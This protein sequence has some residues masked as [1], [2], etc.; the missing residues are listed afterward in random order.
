MGKLSTKQLQA[1]LLIIAALL[2]WI[3]FRIPA[4]NDIA[5]VL[6]VVVAVWLMI[7]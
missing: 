7:K 5:G 2:I 3:P 6:A 4:S 1:V